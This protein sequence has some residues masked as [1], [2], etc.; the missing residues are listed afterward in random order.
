MI[1]HAVG[2]AVMELSLLGVEITLK[3]IIDKLQ[4]FRRETGS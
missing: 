1:A 3:A 4:G 2:C